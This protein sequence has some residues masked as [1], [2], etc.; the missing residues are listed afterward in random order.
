[1]ARRLLTLPWR[2]LK[3][4]FLFIRRH[5]KLSLVL[6]LI[7]AGIGFW[8]YRRTQANQVTLVFEQ[9][10][11]QNLVKTL[12]VSGVV[13]AQEKA[14]LRFLAGGKL[15]YLGAQEGEMVTKGQTLAVIDQASLKKQLNQDLNNYM[16]ERY[17]WEQQNIDTYVNEL[18]TREERELKQGQLDLT[19]EVL[20]V[21]IRDIAIANTRLNAPFDGILTVTPT[22]VI[23]VQLLS[24]DIF[25]VINPQ[26]LV[27]RAEVDEADIAQVR[28]GQS[29]QIEL[30]AHPD[31]K[32][33]TTLNYI[34]F[35]SSQNSTGTVFIVEMP[36]DTTYYGLGFYRLGLRGD[37]Q[38]ILETKNDVL[39]IPLI[40][41]RQRDDKW[42]VD[43]QSGKNEAM[44]REI[45][46]GLETE[47]MIE[48]LSGLSESDQVVIPQ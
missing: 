5:W 4:I 41:T 8:Y 2:F 13:D 46:V 47:D 34:S 18:T 15:T 39:A 45:T 37:A 11:R 25:E 17:D 35:T 38:I 10:Q 7:L 20:D 42:F 16:K 44:E 29:V 12:E 21:E 14:Q 23:G 3:N 33:T 32:I 28:E 31:D 1:M 27:F 6:L 22:S 40:A 24:T 19:N 48:V 43:V 36:L 26:T 9:P 30:D